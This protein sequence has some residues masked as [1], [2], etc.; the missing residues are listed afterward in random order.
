[1]PLVPVRAAR[2]IDAKSPFYYP[3]KN[4]YRGRFGGL[5]LPVGFEKPTRGLSKAYLWAF[6]NPFMG[7]Q[8]PTYGFSGTHLWAFK[9]LSMGLGSAF[10]ARQLTQ[11]RRFAIIPIV[12]G[13]EIL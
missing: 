2:A 12:R 13:G 7:F 11:N 9:S 1:M 6:K 5:K 3:P 10:K 8:E 4:S